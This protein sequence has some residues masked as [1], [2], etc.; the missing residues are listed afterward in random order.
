MFY[1]RP[2]ILG[3]AC[4]ILSSAHGFAQFTE[5]AI[6]ALPNFNEYSRIHVADLNQD[7]EQDIILH[8]GAGELLYFV[9]RIVEDGHF[10]A[11]RRLG[12]IDSTR[13]MMM[14]T[15]DFDQDGDQD[16]VAIASDPGSIVWFENRINASETEFT[17][18]GLWL[19]L[20]AGMPAGTNP[21]FVEVADLDGDQRDDIIVGFNN[22]LGWYRNLAPAGSSALPDLSTL[23]VL[24]RPTRPCGR[25]HMHDWNGD[26]RLDLLVPESSV[27]GTGA[28][29][30][31]LWLYLSETDSD[32]LAF[33]PGKIVLQMRAG[34][35]DFDSGV[36]AVATFNHNNV[37]PIDVVA[38]H[39]RHGARISRIP[40]GSLVFEPY[41]GS[42]L[43]R[44]ESNPNTSTMTL[45]RETQIASDS[46]RE[47]TSQ[48]RFKP[49]QP[50]DLIPADFNRDG[51]ID[52]LMNFPF[53]WLEND[54]W[55]NFT[56]HVINPLDVSPF[57]ARAL[58]AIPADVDQDGYMDVIALSAD[59]SELAWY[60]NG[61]TA[62]NSWGLYQ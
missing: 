33:Q 43:F 23:Q 28:A 5:H 3:L 59:G 58:N 60:R 52:L 44:V 37:P 27:S 53:A 57:Y 26:G 18:H 54:G 46:Y 12:R 29:A 40:F 36:I 35:F 41:Q 55:G 39:W 19:T 17:T 14:S 45:R 10:L 16:L 25:V 9:N 56:N 21:T 24:I 30:S 31:Q 49:N 4:L 2:V 1:I 48:I 22:C 13:S 50:R 51:K 38:S 61:Y 62:V 6:A 20:P 32:P 34:G 15:G 47:D 7:G 8:D 11:P 42:N